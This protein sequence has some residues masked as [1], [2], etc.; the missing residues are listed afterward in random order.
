[1]NAIIG[2]AN[3]LAQENLEADQA[4]F[5]GH[6]QQA[7]KN[8]LSIINDILDLSKIEA[9]KMKIEIRPLFAR[10]NHL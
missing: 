10:R 8:L 7:G 1:M 2:F 9:G 5:V 4:E 6:I 3:V